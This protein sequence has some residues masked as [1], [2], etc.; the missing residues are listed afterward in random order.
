MESLEMITMDAV[1]VVSLYSAVL[2]R[3][4]CPLL[5]KIH[6]HAA[7]P[8]PSSQGFSWDTLKDVKF[9]CTAGDFLIGPAIL[10]LSL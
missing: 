10:G 1:F 4:V 3:E 9:S 2:A 7:A 5:V 6:S 8:E